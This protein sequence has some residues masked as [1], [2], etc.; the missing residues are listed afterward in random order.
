MKK[1]ITI[2]LVLATVVLC[3]CWQGTS[4]GTVTIDVYASSAPNGS[5]SPSFA[6]YAAKAMY[7]LENGLAVNGDRATDPTAY[8]QA[9]DVIDAWEIAVTSF[10]SWRGTINPASPFQNEYGNRLHFGLHI[11]GNGAKFSISQLSFA[12]HSSDATDSLLCTFATG[13]YNYSTSY[14]G[15]NYGTDGIKGTADDVRITSGA[16]TQL[17]DELVSRG[18]GNAWWPMISTELPTAQAAMDDYLAWL[19]SEA[20]ITVTGSYSLTSGYSGSDSV[21]VIPEPMTL[22]LL[23]L[24]VIGL[25]RKKK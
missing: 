19:R 22:C 1:L 4:F 18:S 17:V 23:G 8:T 9:P 6:G 7:A 11:L 14:V 12:M 21:T 2:N 25:I 3:M 10:K 15:I 16:N 13:S 20:P 24:G 5:G